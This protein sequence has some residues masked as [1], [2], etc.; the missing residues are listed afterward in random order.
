MAAKSIDQSCVTAPQDPSAPYR[1]LVNGL[2][3]ALPF[4][5]IVIVTIWRFF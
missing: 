3:I 4:W 5:G 1:G 2:L